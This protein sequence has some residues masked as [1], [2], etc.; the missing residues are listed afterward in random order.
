V[1]GYDASMRMLRFKIKDDKYWASIKT[2]LLYLGYVEENFEVE[3]PVD[4][5][6]ARR[7]R[8]L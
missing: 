5:A 7:L 6:L 1:F 8:E 2:M 4:D 3:I